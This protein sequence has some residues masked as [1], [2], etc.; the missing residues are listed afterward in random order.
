MKK[1]LVFKDGKK[2]E[3]LEEN[4]KFYFCKDSQFRKSNDSIAG[5]EL[6]EEKESDYPQEDL[7]SEIAEEPKKETKKKSKKGE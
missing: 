4:G 2:K 7:A 5:I 3:I 6:K 1:Y